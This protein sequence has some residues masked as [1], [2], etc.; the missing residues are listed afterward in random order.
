MGNGIQVR[1]FG[2]VINDNVNEMVFGELKISPTVPI[3]SVPPWVFKD[4]SIDL[5]LLDE[6][7]S[8]G[9]DKFRVNSFLM[10]TC[11][12]DMIL[13]TD[14]S[15]TDKGFSGFSG[16]FRV[17]NPQ[18]RRLLA[19]LRLPKFLIMGLTVVIE[20]LMEKHLI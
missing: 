16:P 11:E 7:Q 20:T 13:H 4:V 3:P 10:E 8:S 19:P 18:K 6:R 9:I 14:A 5:G 12:E 17:S 2:W 15:K 1:T